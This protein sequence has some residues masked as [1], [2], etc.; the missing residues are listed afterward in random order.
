[1]PTQS[2]KP[3][4]LII[5]SETTEAERLAGAL[6]E[7][8]LIGQSVS[9]PNA[10]RLES[11]IKDRNC[12]LVLCCSYDR[13][14]DLD[15]VLTSYK[16]ITTDTPLIL[17]VDPDNWSA[18]ANKAGRFGVRDLV[19]RYDNEHLGLV[20]SREFEDLLK[21]REANGLS[22]RL[23][24]CEASTLSLLEV[25]SA[26]VAFVQDGMHVDANP[27]YVRLF[28]Y[29]DPDDILT[30]TLLDLIA[31]DDQKKIRDLLKRAE[32]SQL[33]DSLTLDVKCVLADAREIQ[34]RVLAAPAE[35]DGEPCLRVIIQPVQ[36]LETRNTGQGETESANFGVQRF[37]EAI[38]RQV[39]ED[40]SVET[41]FAIFYVRIAKS[42]DLKRNMGLTLALEQFDEFQGRLSAIVGDRGSVTRLNDDSFGIIAHGMVDL[43]AKGLSEHLKNDARLSSGSASRDGTDA[44]LE[45]GYFVIS[46][47]AAAAEDILNAAYRLCIGHRYADHDHKLGQDAPTS[48]AAKVKQEDAADDETIARKIEYA[49]RNDQLRLVYQPIISLMG[50][51]Q[52]NYSVLLRL[53]DEDENLLEARD[54]I[55]A[56]IRKGLIEEIDKWTIRAAIQVIGEQRSAGHN[57]SLFINLSEDTFRN[58]SIVLWICDC[59][60]EFDVRGNWLTFQFQEEL[61]VGNLASIGKLVETL[62]KIKCRVAINRFGVAERPETLLQGMSLDFVLL[63]PSFAQNLADDAEKQQRLLQLATLA[64][65]FN[66]K[67]I[68]TGVEDARALTVLWTAGVDYVQGNFLQRPSPT[69]E[70]Q[71]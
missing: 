27:A 57:L 3:T 31:A 1:M 10:E 60:R 44:D 68:V 13:D 17:M 37:L 24:N 25:T 58:P 64:R 22:A 41:P 39:N 5:I 20:V 30:V 62:K 70:V 34:A 26:G 11:V 50:D 59:L 32:Q 7:E 15:S 35:F 16:Q 19:R 49:L 14:V 45:I 8:G 67:S 43:D 40:R 71:A 2:R 52:E 55:G 33:V 51:N 4:L 47:R 69:L 65:E 28:G 42:G 54:F 63:K 6:R 66:V 46:E 29:T 9:I 12:D 18:V 61:V 36:S 48:L 53:L 56:A 38:E 21:R 23:Q